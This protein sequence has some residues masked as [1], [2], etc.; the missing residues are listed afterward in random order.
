MVKKGSPTATVAPFGRASKSRQAGSLGL[1]G[2]KSDG[3]GGRS[4]GAGLF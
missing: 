3:G 4:G 2:G 1:A